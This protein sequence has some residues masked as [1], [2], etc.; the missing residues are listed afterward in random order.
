MPELLT[1]GCMLTCDCGSDPMPFNALDL[2]GKPT[3]DGLPAATIEEIVPGVNVPSFVMCLSELNPAVMLETALAEGVPTPAPCEPVI[4]TSWVPPSAVLNYDG[5]P[6]ATIASTC[7]CMW[8]GAITVDTPSEF[9][10]TDES[11]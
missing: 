7:L 3:V 10:V 2:P 1:S 4:V 11:V 8:E 5:V 9:S 6:L